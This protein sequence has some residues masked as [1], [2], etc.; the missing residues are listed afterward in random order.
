M[1]R[2][3]S[4]KK[5][6]ILGVQI[7]SKIG[8]KDA[9]F[10][11]ISELLN[12]HSW[13]KP[14]LIVLPEVFN[15]G[16]DH[17]LFK[18]MAEPVGGVSTDFLSSLAKQH[19]ANIVGGSFIEK[20][21]DGSLKNTS[22]VFDR[23]GQIIGRYSK[24]HLFSYYG[25]NEGKYLTAGDKAVVVNTD[26]GRIGLSICYDL[27]FPELYRTLALAGAEVVVCPAAWPYPRHDHWITLSKARAIENQFCMVS[28]NQCGKTAPEWTNLGHSMVIDPW[29]QVVACA[30]SN[31]GVVMS[32]IDLDRV[33]RLR[34]EFPV[35]S[36]RNLD[37]YT[38][39]EFNK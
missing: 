34:E 13:Y 24:I 26:F 31:E 5:I 2:K 3:V 28:V 25:I 30:G 19:A 15:T 22:L 11:K 6:R 7:N 35:L 36:D 1:T 37:A 10:N 4:T 38:I 39:S 27:R 32:E 14:D 9:N 12:E 17:E 20:C 18:K 33:S 23:E 16:V 21:P 29:G 8:D